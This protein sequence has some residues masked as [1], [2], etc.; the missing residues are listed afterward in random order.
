M[1]ARPLVGN[2]LWFR[3]RRLGWGWA[4]AS[5]EG[6]VV[7]LATVTSLVAANQLARAPLA[8][9]LSLLI[10]AT[11]VVICVVKGTP[12]GGPRRVRKG[13]GPGPG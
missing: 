11:S 1:A 8:L 3:P 7:A 13:R 5:W 12:P 9:G 4:P 10:V 2:K 6:W